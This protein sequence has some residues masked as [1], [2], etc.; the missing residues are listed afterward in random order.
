MKITEKST[1]TCEEVSKS[2]T[3][4]LMDVFFLAPFLAY[5]GFKA[6]GLSK[7]EL[8]ILYAIAGGTLYYNARNYLDTKKL[9]V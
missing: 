4:R 6:K 7:A 5:V 9:Q 8:L 2:Q 3:V 1:S